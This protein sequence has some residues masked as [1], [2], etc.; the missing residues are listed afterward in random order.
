M[1]HNTKAPH[2]GQ[3]SSNGIVRGPR[4]TYTTSN[5][6]L[7]RNLN[8]STHFDVNRSFPDLPPIL[9]QRTTMNFPYQQHPRNPSESP[10]FEDQQTFVQLKSEDGQPIKPNIICKIEKGFFMSNDNCWTCYRRNYF[11]VAC[12]YTLSQHP[13]G[14]GV[15]LERSKSNR[16]EQVQAMAMCLSAVVDGTAGKAVDLIQHTPKRDRGPQTTVQKT[17]I[18]PMTEDRSNNPQDLSSYSIHQPF[19]MSHH[20]QIP[21]PNFPLQQ[22]ADTNNDHNDD[23]SSFPGHSTLP[24]A[25]VH[26]FE[27]IQ[28]K[29]ATANNGKRRA[30][31]QYYHLI[32]ELWADVRSASNSKPDWVKVAQKL[33]SQV[34]VRGRSPSHYS[35]EG[36]NSV[37]RTP[38]SCSSSTL[39]GP[40]SGSPP[41]SHWVPSMAH[42]SSY[43]PP[44]LS[45]YSTGG[46]SSGISYSL[47]THPHSHHHQ[48]DH[49]NHGSAHLMPLHEN[50]HVEPIKNLGAGIGSSSSGYHYLPGP[51]LESG[52]ASPSAKAMV[53]SES[54]A[55]NH[56]DDCRMTVDSRG[57]YQ[58]GMSHDGQY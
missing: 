23:S 19:S 14:R 28:F 17:K 2:V 24:H 6:G 57:I 15:Y 49:S 33:S 43:Q 7:H 52:L 22:A 45:R 21:H 25:S 50:S 39:G 4:D 41:S 34:V 44:P 37:V 46:A 1:L 10:P 53:K 20:P 32:V 56:Q 31:Q 8:S 16:Y 18:M 40:S 9:T 29:S 26:T 27:R 36:P 12:R 54:R 47:P 35:N 55:G 51:L 38:G 13:Y 5:P 42:A 30:Q 11:S 58:F 3:S 48:I